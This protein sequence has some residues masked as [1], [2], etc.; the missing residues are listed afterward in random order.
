MNINTTILVIDGNSCKVR[1]KAFWCSDST[2]RWAYNALSPST[3]AHSKVAETV[4]HEFNLRDAVVHGAQAAK[5][6]QQ[7][8]HRL[9]TYWIRCHTVRPPH[10]KTQTKERN[11]FFSSD[12]ILCLCR[13]HA[14]IDPVLPARQLPVGSVLL[15]HTVRVHGNPIAELT[16]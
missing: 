11:I 1:N 4:P 13:K 16:A 15:H 2:P 6:S 3:T 10:R 8:H 5:S 14:C 12:I 9:K 7:S